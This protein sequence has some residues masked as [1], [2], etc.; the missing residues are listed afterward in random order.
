M[1]YDL[2]KQKAV[3]YIGFSKKTEF[4]VENKLKKLN[5]DSNDIASIINEL[6]QLDYIDDNDY[7]NSYI[8]Q[9][10]RLCKYSIYEIKQKLLQKGINKILIETKLED[11]YNSDYEDK[12]AASV[13]KSKSKFMDQLKLKAYLYKRGLKKYNSEV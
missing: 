13:I 11:L 12:V 10:K 6:K 7:I 9:C 3:K 4:E 8:T 1:D 2:A 5:I